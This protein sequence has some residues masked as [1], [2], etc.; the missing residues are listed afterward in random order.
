MTYSDQTELGTAEPEI[1]EEPILVRPY[2]RIRQHPEGPANDVAEEPADEVKGGPPSDDRPAA[3][4]DR[5]GP[6][7][8]PGRIGSA[9]AGH[10]SAL[11]RRRRRLLSV[12][13]GALVLLLGITALVL[14][15]GDRP[16]SPA[17]DAVGSA[18]PEGGH[19]TTGAAQAPLPSPTSDTPSAA[20]A[21]SLSGPPPASTRPPRPSDNTQPSGS[22]AVDEQP[23]PGPPPP[24]PPPPAGARTGRITGASGL[25]LDGG[26]GPHA[27]KV[28]RWNCDGSPGQTWTV[29][30]DGTMQT[31]GRCLQASGGQVTLQ[32]CDGGP[33]QRW[34]S[35]VAGSLV[36][37][38]SGLCLGGPDDDE[39]SRA[40]QRMAACNQSDTQR[41]TLP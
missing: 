10:T 7:R 4:P 11:Q 40:A 37:S 12:S 33:A 31:Q 22:P 38:A 41:W 13:S 3:P 36:S 19:V 30:G 26:A 9:L 25:C 21:S 39:D 6:A 29:A 2:V 23:A 16:A 5:T 17:V 1:D 15:V 8:S 20:T 24:P 14:A 32:T 27:D 34:R 18:T 35:G 28:R